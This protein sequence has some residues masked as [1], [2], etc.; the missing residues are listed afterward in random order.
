ME[1]EGGGLEA[2]FRC[3]VAEIDSLSS[4]HGTYET[5]K[6]AFWPWLSC[7]SPFQLSKSFDRFHSEA[8]K[9]L[10]LF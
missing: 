2:G 6:A 7:Q 1:I 5:V 8:V 10:Q 4:E 3:V 9:F